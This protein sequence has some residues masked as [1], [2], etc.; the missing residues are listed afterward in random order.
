MVGLMDIRLS[1]LSI[2]ILGD[3]NIYSLKDDQ[4]SVVKSVL[5]NY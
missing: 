5:E 2:D 4:R 1:I 3:Y